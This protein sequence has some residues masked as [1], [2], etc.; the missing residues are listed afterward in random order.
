MAVCQDV[1]KTKTRDSV[2]A[3][4]WNTF[5]RGIGARMLDNIDFPK[6]I[7]SVKLASVDCDESQGKS[8]W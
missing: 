3:R 1:I 5:A 7:A 6:S 8:L 2:D 4:R